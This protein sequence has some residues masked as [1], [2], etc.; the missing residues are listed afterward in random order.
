MIFEGQCITAKRLPDDFVELKFD[1]QNSSVNKLNLAT[2]SELKQAIAAIS[3][4]AQ[5][6]QGMIFSSAKKDFIVGADIT[7]FKGWFALPDEEFSER[8]L[9][10]QKTFANIEDLPFPTVCAM[11]GVALG[12][13][14]ELPL[15]TDYR[16]ISRQA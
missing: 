3:K 14:F 6:I 11:N 15:S 9:D 8:L 10:V 16:V 13:G 1:L 4:E 2:I 12:G 7:E 5:T